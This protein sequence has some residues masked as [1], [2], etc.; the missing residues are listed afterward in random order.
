M[1]NSP[2]VPHTWL[3]LYRD[4]QRSH[5]TKI[6][7]EVKR[8]LTQFIGGKFNHNMS[9][10]LGINTPF[11]LTTLNAMGVSSNLFDASMEIYHACTK[12]SFQCLVKG[13]ITVV[14]VPCVT[15]PNAQQK[16]CF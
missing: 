15:A 10:T 13:S 2:G 5:V 1:I 9:C 8:N 11:Q 7:A 14:K 12:R 16:Y 3:L 6:T 4:N